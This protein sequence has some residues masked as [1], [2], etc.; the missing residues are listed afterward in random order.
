MSS[1]ICWMKDNIFQIPH[2]RQA[3]MRKLENILQDKT[4]NI[5]VKHVQQIEETCKIVFFND[6]TEK[7]ILT[8]VY[9]DSTNCEER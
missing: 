6:N 2:N 9:K 5:N 8:K 3:N 1:P 7:E 4:R